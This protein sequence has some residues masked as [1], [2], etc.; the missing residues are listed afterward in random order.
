MRARRPKGMA[1]D[2]GRLANVRLNLI[3]K[4]V[5][6][7]RRERTGRG[8]VAEGREPGTNIGNS[9]ELSAMPYIKGT[10]KH[11]R[12]ILLLPG[13]WVHPAGLAFSLPVSRCPCHRDQICN[14]PLTRHPRSPASHHAWVWMQPRHLCGLM[15]STPSPAGWLLTWGTRPFLMVFVCLSSD[16]RS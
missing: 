11:H 10:S 13:S 12:R 7:C 4:V 2:S 9:M 15:L 5:R 8:R 16:T 1:I 3:I 6:P 14:R